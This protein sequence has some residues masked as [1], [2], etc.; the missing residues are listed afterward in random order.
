VI[1]ALTVHTP[2]AHEQIKSWSYATP[3]GL[4]DRAIHLHVEQLLGELAIPVAR[5]REIERAVAIGAELDAT[6]QLVGHDE[7]V[8]AATVITNSCT[9]S[10]RESI[11][12]CAIDG[13]CALRWL[14]MRRILGVV[15]VLALTSCMAELPIRPREQCSIQGMV[16][17]GASMKLGD[18]DPQ[19]NCRRPE[20][21]SENCEV[22][23]AQ[24]SID[25][26]QHYETGGRNFGLFIAYALFII[27][28]VIL[29]A[30]LNDERNDIGAK[31]DGLFE[32]ARQKC[33][34]VP[35]SE[36]LGAPGL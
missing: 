21:P 7:L 4:R 34:N 18:D 16:L 15:T 30:A 28:G 24:Q 9:K 1:D 22:L 26:R 6:E 33:L 2:D 23:A 11:P 36:H 3:Q 35:P 25:V 31:A 29:H 27:P 14:P 32:M 19:L 8:L 13:H 12:T 5:L 20:S 10:V 17:G